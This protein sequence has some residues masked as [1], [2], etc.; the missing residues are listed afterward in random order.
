MR[1]GL[2][3]ALCLG[4]CIIL[5]LVHFPATSPAQAAVESVC[6]SMNPQALASEDS[7]QGSSRWQYGLGVHDSRAPQFWASSFSAVCGEAIDIHAAGNFPLSFSVWRLG[8][9]TGGTGNLKLHWQDTPEVSVPETAANPSARSSGLPV[10]TTVVPRQAV[11]T[12]GW[13]L[14]QSASASR[15]PITTSFKVDPNWLPGFYWIVARSATFTGWPGTAWPLIIRDSGHTQPL[16]IVVPTFTWQAYN[17]WGSA[18]LYAYPNLQ[19]KS[20]PT[21][22]AD[23]VSFERPLADLFQDNSAGAIATTVPAFVEK[24]GLMASWITDGDLACV[25]CRIASTKA[26]VL[27]NHDEYW[28]VEERRRLDKLIASGTNLVVL[29]G[30]SIYHRSIYSPVSK[31]LTVRKFGNPLHSRDSAFK[32]SWRFEDSKW[33]PQS[34]NSVSYACVLKPSQQDLVVTDPK[35]WAWKA[36]R[37]PSGRIIKKILGY[38]VDSPAAVPNRRIA[39][40]AGAKVHCANGMQISAGVVYAAENVSK[41]GILNIGS[42]GWLYGLDVQSSWSS[43]AYTAIT[44]ADKSF[45]THVTTRILTEASRGPLGVKFPVK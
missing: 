40:P 19:G 30:N 43:P 44:D 18:S 7:L 6:A 1:F 29:G 13:P 10:G 20:V 22:Q 3:R 38:E 12:D 33:K 28:T 32:L 36:E 45:V 17:A 9:Y 37:I 26:I 42:T 16:T 23:Q 14:F 11:G 21:L 31:T 39:S 8:S 5:A 15:W 34:T 4:I 25:Q 35:F 2:S 41:A 24:Q 27:L